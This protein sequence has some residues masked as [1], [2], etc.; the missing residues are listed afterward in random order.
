[1]IRA[2]EVEYPTE[3]FQYGMYGERKVPLRMPRFL[4]RLSEFEDVDKLLSL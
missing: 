2:K 4:E 3:T 1:M